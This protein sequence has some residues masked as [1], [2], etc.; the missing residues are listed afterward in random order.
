MDNYFKKNDVK[1]SIFS[2][3]LFH[4]YKLKVVIK[5]IFILFS[6]LDLSKKKFKTNFKFL[7]SPNSEVFKNIDQSNNLV[8]WLKK[9]FNDGDEN[10]IMITLD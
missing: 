3:F 1:V 8:L 7:S 9:Y 2:N 5:S 4:S 6:C 10:F